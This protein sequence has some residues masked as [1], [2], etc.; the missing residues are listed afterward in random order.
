MNMSV[1]KSKVKDE[2]KDDFSIEENESSDI[3]TFSEGELKL[4]GTLI[5]SFSFDSDEDLIEH[6]AP[7]TIHDPTTTTNNNNNN[8]NNSNNSNNNNYSNNDST[9]TTP[10]LNSHDIPY[11]PDVKNEILDHRTLK[12]N[13]NGRTPSV[14]GE[15]FDMVRSYTLRRSTVRILSKIKAIHI[16]DNV[17][18]N[19]I[20]DE[21]IRYYYEYLKTQNN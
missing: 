6:P 9:N 16:D 11:N 5:K 18:L 8:N 15:A 19:T 21:A 10:N 3:F 12:V 1:K 13:P 4:D 2:I 7:P 17:Y 14:D 20:V